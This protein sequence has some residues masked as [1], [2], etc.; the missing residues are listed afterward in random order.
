MVNVRSKIA[1]E[2][3]GKVGLFRGA[4][5]KAVLSAR[6]RIATLP[7]STG[8]GDIGG[9]DVVQG[10]THIEVGNAQRDGL[11]RDMRSQDTLKRG[12]PGKTLESKKKNKAT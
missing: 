2:F 3:A 4:S 10:N 9:G 11:V 6:Q 8:R 1:I 7:I 12:M 5:S